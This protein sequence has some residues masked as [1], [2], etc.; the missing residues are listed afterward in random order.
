MKEIKLV[1]TEPFINGPSWLTEN[2]GLEIIIISK[3]GITYE[4]NGRTGK[5]CYRRSALQSR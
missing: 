5:H 4:R 1:I 3:S 2:P